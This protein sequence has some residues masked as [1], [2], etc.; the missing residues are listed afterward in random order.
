[1]SPTATKCFYYL[2]RFQII[3]INVLVFGYTNKEEVRDFRDEVDKFTT[4]LKDESS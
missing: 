4:T 2:L 3:L 1:M